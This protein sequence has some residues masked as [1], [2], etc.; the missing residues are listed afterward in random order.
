[1]TKVYVYGLKENQKELLAALCS[2]FDFDL[3]LWDKEAL[4]EQV[5]FLIDAPG[6]QS[7]GE[8]VPE[9]EETFL[10]FSDFPREKLND[11]L[12][13]LR[14]QVAY[15]P[16]KAHVTENN[17]K[18]RLYDLIAH[19]KEEHQVMELYNRLTRL[20]PI[21]QAL[22]EQKENPPLRDALHRAKDYL[23]LR[24]FEFEELKNIYNTLA[25]TTNEVLREYE[26]K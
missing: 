10:L 5:G 18:W 25:S 24:E 22:L 13:N 12:K 1:M 15:F 17:I 26:K 11:F 4:K 6:F 23:H 7:S 2:R 20:F 14:E 19:N 9:V 16:L 3:I 8:E 21:A